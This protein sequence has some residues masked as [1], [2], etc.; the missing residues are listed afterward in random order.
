MLEKFPNN[1]N[2]AEGDQEFLKE[3]FQEDDKYW[4]DQREKI[5][6]VKQSTKDKESFDISVLGMFYNT[7][8]YDSQPLIDSKIIE[9]YEIEYYLKHPEIKSL[10]E[11]AKYKQEF[12][13]HDEA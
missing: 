5:A 12:E 7:T 1:I 2:K 4:Q 8:G 6:L 3:V 11:F 9:E 13:R 10:E